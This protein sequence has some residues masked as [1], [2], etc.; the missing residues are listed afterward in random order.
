MNFKLVWFLF[1]IGIM[2]GCRVTREFVFPTVEEQTKFAGAI[3]IG[4]AVKVSNI[5]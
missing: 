3:V 4:T 2:N 5:N 1:L